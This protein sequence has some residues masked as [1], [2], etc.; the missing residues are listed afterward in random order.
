MDLEQITKRLDWID[1]ERRKDKT[2]IAT[3]QE[4]LLALEGNIPS[5][6]QQIKDMNGEI[7]RL[8][9]VMARLDQF[10]SSLAQTRVDFSRMVENNEKLRTDHEREVDKVRRVELEGVNK[11]IGEVR[12]GLEPIPDLR[13]A[14]QA[15]QEEE[16]RLVH[17]I[18]EINQ[19]VVETNRYDEEYKRS[20]RLIEEGRRQD[21]KRLTD[22][23]GEVAA[24]R[25]RVDEQ[26]GKVDIT[27]DNL[28]KLETRIGELLAAE[29]ER[30]QSQTSFIEKQTLWQVE[31]DR[32]WK[33]WQG[34]FEIIEKS[35]INLDAQLQALDATQRSV[36][37]SQDALDDATQRFDR[38]INEITEMQRLG[39][40]RFRQEWVTFKADDQKRWT[41]YTLAQEEQLREEGRRFDKVTERL[42]TLEDL[43]QELQDVIHQ[44]NIE[45]DKRLQGLITLAHEWMAAYENA[46]GRTA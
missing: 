25:K 34:R 23:Q 8:I 32:T 19:K 26:R 45:T 46:F 2:T 22:I 24:I 13:K 6:T 9:T 16:F 15:R 35:A 20:L 36:K 29:S 12:K 5:L 10:E 31:R 42:V 18:E 41:N 37:R 44:I 43:T 3:L 40:D 7:T 11:T 4:R 17:L 21:A 38:R 14:I 33:E 1:E 27:S 39:E 28:R 30:R